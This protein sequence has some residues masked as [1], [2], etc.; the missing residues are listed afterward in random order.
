MRE[1]GRSLRLK[2]LFE[3]SHPQLSISN[4]IDTNGLRLEKIEP[5]VQS[6]HILDCK[7]HKRT[8]YTGLVMTGL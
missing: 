4:C 5:S 6:F 7:N 3:F 2:Y 1:K 8:G